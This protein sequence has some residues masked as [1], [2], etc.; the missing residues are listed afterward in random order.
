M[1]N[2]IVLKGN[3]QFVQKVT[4]EALIDSNKTIIVVGNITK[5]A[6]FKSF[7]QLSYKT[8]NYFFCCSAFLIF[9]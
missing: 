8:H 3:A 6:I 2:K 5:A 7:L 1:Q 9:S 4:F